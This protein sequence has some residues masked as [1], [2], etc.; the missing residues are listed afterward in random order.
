L[1]VKAIKQIVQRTAFTHR[2]QVLAD[3]DKLVVQWAGPGG[4]TVFHPKSAVDKNAS[5][6]DRL[7]DVIKGNAVQVF[8]QIEST[9]GAFLGI[10]DIPTDK[11]LQNLSRER[12]WCLGLTTDLFDANLPIFLACPTYYRQ[13]SDAVFAAVGEHIFELV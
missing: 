5:P 11:I 7:H 9:G 3:C 8:G 13:G 10:E 12:L 1:V 6:I 2:L 4:I